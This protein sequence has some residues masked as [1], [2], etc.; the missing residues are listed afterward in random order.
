MSRANVDVV[1]AVYDR[2][3]DGDQE[4]GLA[5]YHPDVEVHDRPEVPDPHVYH[6]HAGVLAARGE[7]R[8]EFAGHDIVPE[9]FIDRGDRVVVVFRFVGQGRESGVP[10]EQRLCHAWEVRDGLVT[11]M[12]VHSTRESAL[13]GGHEGR[14]LRHLRA[15]V[16]RSQ[17]TGKH[18]QPLRAQQDGPKLPE[19][20]AP[21]GA[22]VP[23]PRAA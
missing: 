23:R 11:R 14:P 16:R 18:V 9:E 17:H 1:R 4:G 10:I 12:E 19:V 2:F 7:S 3:R 21:A 15:P 13:A 20:P 22:G 5:L 6:G 8:S